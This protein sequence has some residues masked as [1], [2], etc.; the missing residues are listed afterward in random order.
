MRK[1]IYKTII[2]LVLSFLIFISYFSLIGFETKRFN[3]QISNKIK[4]L[5]RELEL[6]LNKVKL[7]LD[8]FKFQINAKTL[9]SQLN[10]NQKSIDFEYIK[11]KISLR[12]LINNEFSLTN[13]EASTKSI[14]IKKL[15]S[16]IQSV[17]HSVELFFL[18]RFIKKGYLLTDI[19]LN[20][21]ENGKLKDNFKINGFVK[22]TK[23]NILKDYKIK[24][25]DF[26][27]NSDGKNLKIQDLKL[28]LNN[29]NFL[30]KE[31]NINKIDNEFLFN[32][33]IENENS[34]LR[35]VDIDLFL[36]PF[37]QNI[38]VKKFEFNSKNKFSF[39]LSKKLKLKDFQIKSFFNVQ[40]FQILNDLKLNK[41]FP[42]IK[43][44]IIFSD[45]K[46]EIEYKTN[47]LIVKGSGDIF[48]QNQKDKIDY[49]FNIKNKIKN[50]EAL[51]EI[52]NNPLNL[53]ILDYKKN[54]NNNAVIKIRGSKKLDKKI[55]FDL[56]SLEEKNN[57]IN[58]QNLLLDKKNE[59]IDLEKAN[60]NYLDQADNIN[61]FELIK[62]KNDYY[63]KGPIFNAD[64][65][66]EN[67]IKDDDNSRKILNKKIKVLIKID[68]LLLDKNYKLKNFEGD[69]SLKNQEIISGNLEGL[70]SKNKKFKFTVKSIDNKK[71]TTLFLDE[72]DTMVNR[73]EFIKGFKGGSLDFYSTKQNNETLGKIKIY[74]FKLK[75]LP[76]L[77]KLLTLA[78][79][80]GI[81]DIVS[82]E[83]ISFDEF[84]MTF[85]NNQKILTI[86]EIYAIG[87][88]I[89]ILLKGYV[90]KNKLISLRG[91]LV[92][93]TTINKVIGSIPILG[94][95]L[96]GSKTGEGVFGVSFKIKGPPK[97][98]ET[99]VNPIK[100]LTPRFITRTLEKIKK[101]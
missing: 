22:N 24:D 98:L 47:D 36:K 27:F 101:N 85:K 84:E 100:T 75:E 55:K 12:S 4:N 57:K 38:N 18:E 90:E 65:I 30:S 96:V 62:I 51:I 17:D 74:D 3:N 78:S 81:A 58:I 94:D 54:I 42:N 8:P 5:N 72:A 14:E 71:I 68:N 66:I 79:L 35:N 64:R 45:Q 52:N 9:G 97:K 39:R 29:I 31:L 95:I 61:K 19:K 10:H 70:F 48:L 34:N 6:K 80:Q 16:F 83:G 21:D 93:A 60:F 11:T 49:K 41:I 43:E 23:M 91:T 2:I 86:E 67:F 63:L 59:I 50:F 73:Y 44:K 69:L 32:G 88:A 89:S 37:F 25:L 99:T 7:K 13:L 92:P 82:G 46:L 33:E 53:D 40:E 76:A 56:I 15:I 20:F 26:I 77:T 87:P 28:S 1:L